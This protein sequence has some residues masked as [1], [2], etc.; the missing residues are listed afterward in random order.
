MSIMSRGAERLPSLQPPA[1]LRPH[2]LVLV[3]LHA[4]AFLIL[5]FSEREPFHV[6]LFLLAWG[7]FNFSWLVI[8]RRPSVAAALSLLLLCT[9]VALS[10]VKMSVTWATLSFFDFVIVDPDTFRFLTETFPQLRLELPL[11]ALL[12]LLMLAW[13]WRLDPFRVRRATSLL[14]GT[15]CLA[16]LSALSLAVPELPSEPF[17]GIN[18]IS[19]FVRSGIISTVEYAAHG[20]I[21]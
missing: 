16:G 3:G 19:N 8:F 17:E 20:F 1:S 4:A 18:H 7:W 21:D 6:A 5:C 12:I 10:W 2:A 13:V 14:A 11:A 9:L 15:A